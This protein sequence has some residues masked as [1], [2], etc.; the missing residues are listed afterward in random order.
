MSSQPET[1]FNLKLGDME[2]YEKNHQAPRVFHLTHFVFLLY[3][4]FTVL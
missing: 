4:G 3:C 2:D 1:S